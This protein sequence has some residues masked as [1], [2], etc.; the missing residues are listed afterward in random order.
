LR[1]MLKTNPLRI[2]DSKEEAVQELI[3]DA[4]QI[5]DYLDE[6]SR[7]HFIAVLEYLDE[8]DM[9]YALQ[10]RLVRGLDYYSRTT[11][12]IFLKDEFEDGK[13]LNA[14]GGGGRY[15]GLSQQLGGRPT[16][17]IGAAAGVERVINALRDKNIKI[18]PVKKYDLFIAQLGPEA[19]RK[20][21]TLF[22]I[23]K[24]SGWSIGESFSKDGLSTQLER[25]NKTGA[26]FTLILGQKEILEG[27]IIIRD[28]SSGIQEAVVFDK[29][30]SELEKRIKKIKILTQNNE[31]KPV[32]KEEASQENK[33]SGN[34]ETDDKGKEVTSS[35]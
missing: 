18:P 33:A 22:E 12:E 14:L 34:Q 7:N 26:Q 23:L 8:L 20:A 32:I 10:P 30:I 16:P 29:I 25:A 17:A 3:E 31:V 1:K 11:F 28:M 27:T 35:D 5:V 19:R 15:D 6:E 13:K 9:P 24:D 2:L 4:P 21:L